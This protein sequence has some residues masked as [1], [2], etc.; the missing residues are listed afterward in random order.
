[1]DRIR[2]FF[3]RDWSFE[4]KVLLTTAALLAGIAAGLLL[5]PVRSISVGN[6]CDNNYGKLEEEEDKK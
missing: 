6:N 2:E 3:A 1:M 5:S 4:E